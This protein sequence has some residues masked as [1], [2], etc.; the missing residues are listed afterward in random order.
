MAAGTAADRRKTTAGHKGV[1]TSSE[2]LL[3]CT[4]RLL[5]LLLFHYS[6]IYKNTVID[7]TYWP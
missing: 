2:L 3:N 6:R 5:L 1:K 4:S 7:Y